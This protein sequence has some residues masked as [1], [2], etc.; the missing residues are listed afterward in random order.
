MTRY[1]AGGE[2]GRA[3]MQTVYTRVARYAG[4]AFPLQH[5][6][7]GARTHMLRTIQMDNAPYSEA[8]RL[9][10]ARGNCNLI[11]CVKCKLVLH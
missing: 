4:V 3:W 5:G 8:D 2:S 10:H 1:H 7:D 9:S 11:Y 6:T